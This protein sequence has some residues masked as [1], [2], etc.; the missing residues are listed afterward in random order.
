MFYSKIQ[1]KSTLM[2]E[3]TQIYISES[4]IQFPSKFFL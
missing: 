4:K 1:I 3:F 2:L